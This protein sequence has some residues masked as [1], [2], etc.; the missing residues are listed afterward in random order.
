[1][2]VKFLWCKSGVARAITSTTLST[3]GVSVIFFASVQD[4]RSFDRRD[5]CQRPSRAW[6][7]HFASPKPS[8]YRQELQPRNYSER[9]A[10]LAQRFTRV[11]AR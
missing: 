6:K 2:T 4:V 10:K 1:M 3:I 8:D 5:A 9:D 11:P 7:R